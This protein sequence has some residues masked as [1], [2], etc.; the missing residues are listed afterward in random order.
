MAVK[1]QSTTQGPKQVKTVR[2]D[3]YEI[4][5][6]TLV[7]EARIIS[8]GKARATIEAERISGWGG[9]FVRTSPVAMI[10]S[11][12]EGER[13]IPITDTTFRVMLGLGAA[14]LG[15]ILFFS[16][17]RRLVALRQSVPDETGQ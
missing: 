1:Q 8:F 15:M 13:R 11:S 7:P 17:V 10:E 9:G 6:R 4:D 12:S 14:S 16:A 2:G 5:G 3:P